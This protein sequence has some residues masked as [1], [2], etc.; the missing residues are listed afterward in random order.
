[1][2]K[3]FCDIGFPWYVGK[4]NG[5]LLDHVIYLAMA[6][7]TQ[8]LFLTADLTDFRRCFLPPVRFLTWE[9]GE[10]RGG[11][12]FSLGFLFRISK[13]I[14]KVH[15][16][17]GVVVFWI[18]VCFL[19]DCV[20]VLVYLWDKTE[21]GPPGFWFLISGIDPPWLGIADQG[22]SDLPCDTDVASYL[23]ARRADGLGFYFELFDRTDLNKAP[24][25]SLWSLCPLVE[26][27]KTGGEKS[28][29]DKQQLVPT[30]RVGSHYDSRSSFT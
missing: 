22:R 23:A 30:V 13:K 8:S 9:H 24:M 2:V 14:Q 20:V 21:L 25:F 19:G 27:S 18:V 6:R 17:K 29:V 4:G 3:F 1:M 10:H 28:V 5:C 11:F 16:K 7:R 15:T 26:R 12:E